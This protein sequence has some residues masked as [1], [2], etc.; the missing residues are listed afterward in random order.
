VAEK[1]RDVMAGALVTVR[2]DQPLTVAARAMGER[3]IGAILVVDDGVLQGLLTDRDIVVR[4]IADGLDPAGTPV[5]EVCSTDL[6]TV[7]PDDDIRTAVQCMR[8]HSVRRV[9][10]VQD[11]RPAGVL[12]IGDLAIERDEQSVLAGI[13]AQAPNG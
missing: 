12:S 10:V 4:A 2:S 13:S 7:A 3:A 6:I 9:P 5:G 1:V 11:G 8:D